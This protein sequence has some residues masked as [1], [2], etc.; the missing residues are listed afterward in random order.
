MR[1]RIGLRR[2]LRIPPATPWSFGPRSPGLQNHWKFTIKL[3]FGPLLGRV[4]EHRSAHPSKRPPELPPEAP[5]GLLGESRGPPGGSP[6]A[7]CG[8]PGPPGGT[9]GVSWGSPG[10]SW[11]GPGL[12]P[13]SIVE[14]MWGSRTSPGTEHHQNRS[15]LGPI[16]CPFSARAQFW[17]PCGGPG[18]PQE[19]KIIKIGAIWAP[20]RAHFPPRL[21]EKNYKA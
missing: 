9:P 19:P 5:G 11:G 10:P 8:A 13:G 12:P 1:G 20:F 7:H 14:P 2:G 21:S 17:S 16:S 3:G 4:C 18:P 6:G 15:Y